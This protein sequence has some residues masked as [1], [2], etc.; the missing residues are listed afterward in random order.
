M[1]NGIPI[2]SSNTVNTTTNDATSSREDLTSR[3]LPEMTL[4]TGDETS[5]TAAPPPMPHYLDNTGRALYRFGIEGCGVVTGGAGVLAL[6][7]ARALLEHGLSGLAL[8]DI[9]FAHAASEIFS[10]RSDFPNVKIMTLECDV[11]DEKSVGKAVER[12]VEGLGSVNLLCC[13]AGVVNCAPSLDV[14]VEEW[15]RVIDVNLTGAFICARA[16]GRTMIKEFTPGPIVFIS[17]LS[18]HRVNYPQPQSA[19]NSS[20]AG[21]T[22]LTRSLAAEW[23]VYGIRVNSI[24]PGYMDTILNEGDGLENARRI[25]NTRNPMGRMGVASEITGPLVLL[26]SAAAGGFINGAD[27]KVDGGASIF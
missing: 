12:T 18:A 2:D 10:M 11:T 19:Y 20:K 6:A 16:V 23:A 9:S 22:H 5:N 13:F 15:R 21:L 24:S 1:V 26:C 25:W 17:S 7:S 4:S 14:G 3:Q 27:I 8:W